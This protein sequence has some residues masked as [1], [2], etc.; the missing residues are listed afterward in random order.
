MA[1]YIHSATHEIRETMPDEESTEEDERRSLY[2][3]GKTAKYDLQFKKRCGGRAWGKLIRV[4]A[5]PS[6]IGEMF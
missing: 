6:T 5:Q 2:Q 1:K 3:K 4:V